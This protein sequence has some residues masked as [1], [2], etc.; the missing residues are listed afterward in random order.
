M[1]PGPAYESLPTAAPARPA[2]SSTGSTCAG[3]T[4]VTGPQGRKNGA[5]APAGPPFAQAHA[6]D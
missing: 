6:G 3:S 5:A 4:K 1:R 2:S